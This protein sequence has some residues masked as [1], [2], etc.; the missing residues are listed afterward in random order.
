MDESRTMQ[1]PDR[2]FELSTGEAKEFFIAVSASPGE[3]PDAVLD[4]ALGVVRAKSAAII[5]AKVFGAPPGNSAGDLLRSRGGGVDW[6]VTWI[7]ED[8]ARG[9][10]LSGV[11]IW[12]VAGTP[13]TRIRR[14]DVVLATVFDDEHAR[15]CKLAGVLPDDTASDA[16]A[17]T[18]QVFHTMQGVLHEA[19]MTF[20]HVVRTWFFNDR[21]TS[22]YRVFNDARD[23]FF[24]AHHVFDGIVPASTGIGGSNIMGAALAA[25]LLAVQPKSDSVAVRRVSSPLQCPAFD[26]GSSFSRAVEIDTPDCRRVFISGTASIAPEGYTMHLGE[27]AP[28]MAHTM[29]VIEAILQSR[30]MG[31]EDANRAIAYVKRA[32]DLEL[33]SNSISPLANAP[34]LLVNNDICRDDLLFEIE[35]DAAKMK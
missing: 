7:G 22:W 27:T 30:G 4:R 8:T 28:Q 16:A 13:C 29:H 33:V 6:P 31:W 20:D 2:V 17:Q 25:G 11:Q 21:I 19:G 9:T 10:E 3:P 15:Y 23:D 26:Y 12:A 32:E 35:L 24:Y 18:M 5:S 1:F 34:V 14:G